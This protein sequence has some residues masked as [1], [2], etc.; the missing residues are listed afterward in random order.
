MVERT[1]RMILLC[2]F[3]PAPA[4]FPGGCGSSPAYP[5][6]MRPGLL[7]L[8]DQPYRRL[9]VEVD[10]VE[11]AEAPQ[12]WL[13]DLEA[14]VARYCD[15][16]DGI[17]IVKD[18]PIPLSEVKGL[19]IWEAALLCTDGPRVEEGE[20]PAYL[21]VFFY[22]RYLFNSRRHQG[23]SG[24]VRNPHVSPVC[25]TTIFFNADYV[26][27]APEYMRI[28]LLL[29][30]AG[31]ILG[32]SHNKS[33]GDGTHCRNRGCLMRPG[34]EVESELAR[35][36]TAPVG[37]KLE[38]HL[39]RDCLHDLEA[40]STMEADE[41]LS[42][43]GPFLVRRADGYS[44]VRLPNCEIIEL[45]EEPTSRWQRTLGYVKRQM[46]ESLAQRGVGPGETTG[47]SPVPKTAAQRRNAPNKGRGSYVCLLMA[48]RDKDS[49]E[50]RIEPLLAA[51]TKATEDPC[52]VTRDVAR[53]LLGKVKKSMPQPSM[54][55]TPEAQ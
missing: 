42:F 6:Y 26:H 22:N 9:Y 11:G 55:T 15:K 18:E 21:H 52:P 17:T 16:P 43:A 37:L 5:Q 54:P 20:Q 8:K 50:P 44:V 7:Y 49:P 33:H 12:K 31:H 1:A 46:R 28:E 32:L 19:T 36:L 24:P 38:R 14:F 29:H 34:E 53:G 45:Y 41:K 35:L 10:M 48:P 3:L 2:L 47:E 13:D 25:P 40:A 4:L 39:C 30:E 51:L 23:L 27:M